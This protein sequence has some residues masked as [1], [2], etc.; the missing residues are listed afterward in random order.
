MRTS[1]QGSDWGVSPNV[2]FSILWSMRNN[3]PNGRYEFYIYDS[4][5]IHRN[6]IFTQTN[7]YYENPIGNSFAQK[8]GNFYYSSQANNTSWRGLALGSF[9]NSN[10]QTY[11][12]LAM[13]SEGSSWTYCLQDQYSGGYVTGPWFYDG[14]IGGYDVGSQQWVKVFQR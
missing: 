12:T 11:C 5:T 4:S 10:F 14:S 8:S 1:I 6:A 3:K 2:N 7:A 13:S 9:G